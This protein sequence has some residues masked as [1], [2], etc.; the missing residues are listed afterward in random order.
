MP[1]DFV[2][3][4]VSKVTRWSDGAATEDTATDTGDS[5]VR[6]FACAPCSNAYVSRRMRRCPE[7]GRTV[8]P[9]PD[10][11]DLGFA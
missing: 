7:C 11:Q 3:R 5:A 10:G 8:E 4:M 2:E 9:V 6:L 1:T